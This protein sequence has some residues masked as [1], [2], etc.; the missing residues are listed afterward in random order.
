MNFHNK[1]LGA[2]A[3]RHIIIFNYLNT[4]KLFQYFEV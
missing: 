3:Y 2:C 4:L 1:N